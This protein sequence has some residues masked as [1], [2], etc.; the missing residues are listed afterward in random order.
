M[1]DC[2]W[3]GDLNANGI[4]N[5]LD[6]LAFGFALGQSGPAR[7]NGSTNWEA[8][9]AEDWAGFLPDL[10]TNFK[11]IDADG[12]GVIDEQDRLAVNIN[13]NLTNDLFSGLLGSVIAGNDLFVVPQNEVTS[14]GGTF[15][16]DIHLGSASNPIDSM[17]G[18]GFQLKLDTQLVESVNFDF[19]DSWIGTGSEV[20]TY[21][22][23]DDEI[24]H[25]ATAITRLDGVPVSGFGKIARV[26]IVITDVVLGISADS[27]SCVPFQLEFENVL[28]INQRE[29]DQMIGIRNDTLSL[30]HPSQLTS[31]HTAWG[32]DMELFPNPV[33]D[34]LVVH[35]GR[36]S[37]KSIQLI[38][39]IGQMVWQANYES[40][41]IGN[42]PID[43]GFLPRGLYLIRI[44]GQGGLRT[45][46]IILQ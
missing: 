30:K 35:P 32:A 42:V 23:Y 6:I 16:L 17:Y 14:P 22:K 45:Q 2:V 18:I 10:G 31:T 11:H 1:E 28:G 9:E 26:E 44:T 39:R 3:P 34:Q 38:D 7:T 24:E 37:I 25:A 15:L 33:E 43:L 20:F 29:E 12:N 8:L 5:N 40:P 4:A 13:Y 46:K 41:P 36:Q 21:G 19:S 27:T